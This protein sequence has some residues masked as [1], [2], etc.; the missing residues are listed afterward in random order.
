MIKSSLLE[1][2]A[3]L[4]P[5]REIDRA[6]SGSPED[7]MLKP[8]DGLADVLVITA[9][10]ALAYRGASLLRSKRALETMIGEGKAILSLPTVESRVALVADLA[11]AGVMVRILT[12]PV[13]LQGG[14]VTAF[15]PA[16]R[17]RLELTQEQFA[18]QFGFELLRLPASVA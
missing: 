9:A 12:L 16:L 5:V 7:V 1:R 11:A 18:L 15:L 13:E 6:S 10:R 4:G 3:R 8:L 14:D 2:F 17:A